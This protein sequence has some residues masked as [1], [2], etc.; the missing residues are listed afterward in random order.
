MSPFLV[1]LI[2]GIFLAF[3]YRK[4]SHKS[5]LPKADSEN[6]YAAWLKIV[7]VVS[8]PISIIWVVERALQ[9]FPD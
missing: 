3:A 6:P 8:V 9:S 7:A 1:S 2:L 5:I 4:T